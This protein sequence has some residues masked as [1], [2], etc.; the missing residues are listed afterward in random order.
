LNTATP[1]S[2]GVEKGRDAHYEILRV[3]P[4]ASMDEIRRAYLRL[5]RDAHPDFHTENET[6]RV[7]AEVRMRR[8]NAAWAVLGDVDERSAYDRS[9][10]SG[11]RRA[12]FHG[13]SHGPV[14]EP[15]PWEPFDD[16][17]AAEF[18]DR[19]DR[20]ITASALPSW[21]KTAPALGV[22]FGLAALIFGSLV[23]LEG[24]AEIGLMALVFST[25]LFLAAPIVALSLSKGQDRRP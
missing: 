16:G 6:E 10:L 8:I 23:N 14:A 20:P 21:L 19:D 11:P 5:A 25:L 15:D 3:D 18:D 2:R 1:Y 4:A 17:P 13:A 12:P 24:M 9:R 22:L 7:D